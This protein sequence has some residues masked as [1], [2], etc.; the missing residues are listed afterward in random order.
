MTKFIQKMSKLVLGPAI[1]VLMLALL[2]AGFG[3][4]AALAQTR[5]YVTNGG[6]NTV[7]VIDTAM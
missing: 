5:G 2:L 4:G 1:R 7:S 6:D 3:V